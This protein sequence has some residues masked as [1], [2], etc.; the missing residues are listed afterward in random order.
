M[1][2]VNA[3]RDD[4]RVTTVLGWDATNSKTEPLQVA[5]ASGYLLIEVENV[6]STSP[7]AVTGKRDD[8]YLPVAL[9]VTDN[10]AETVTPLIVDIRDGRLFV[11]IELV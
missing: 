4:N 11:D 3:K 9:A 10:G 6:T 7:G 8:N 2:N 1:P 5:T